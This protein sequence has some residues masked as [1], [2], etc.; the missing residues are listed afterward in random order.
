MPL[1][2]A[3]LKRRSFKK[4]LHSLPSAAY[5]LALLCTLFSLLNPGFLSFY[6][7]M[8]VLA[9][10]SMLII[11]SLGAT[12]II[13]SEGIDLSCGALLSFCAVVLA[14]LLQAGTSLPV[15]FSVVLIL[16]A[17][18]GLLTGVFISYGKLPPFVATFG[19]FGISQ[20]LALVIS[21]GS[22][23]V[24][25]SEFLRQIAEKTWLEIPIPVWIAFCAFLGIYFLL[26]YTRFGRCVFA[27]GGNEEA[28]NLAGV[29]TR[30]YKT[31]IYIL[32]GALSALASFIMVGR[33]NS[34]HPTVAIGMEFDAIASV[35][36]GGTSFEK[37]DG[38]LVRTLYGVGVISVLR[39]G[40][41]LMGI[42]PFIQVPLVGIVIVLAIV[43]KR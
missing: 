29:N 3:T 24:N 13:L 17:L 34:A 10:S 38:G 26:Y 19:T 2:G 40:L 23:V 4:M 31:L 15:A 18:A 27:I 28:A 43:L 21:Q 32:G 7:V 41:N 5:G 9:Q 16:G 39:N 20:G 30:I 11:L 22:S 12:V 25:P 33:L 6:N 35:I 1:L 14:V 42:D 37:G 36:I 8:S